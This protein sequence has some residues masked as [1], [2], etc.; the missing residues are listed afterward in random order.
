M[1]QVK[2]IAEQLSEPFDPQDIEWRVQQAGE[3]NGKKW[4]MVLAYIDNRAIMGRLD[5]V[6]G[7]AGWQN[8]YQPL[9]DGGIICGIKAKIGDEWIVKYDGADKTNIEATKGGLSNAMKRAGAQWGIGRYL[10]GLEATF[11]KPQDGKAPDHDNY[12]SGYS[13]DF[14]K[15]YFE[16]PQLPSWALPKG[17][18]V[19]VT[20][21]ETN[22]E[23]SYDER[24]KQLKEITAVGIQLGYD[25][26][27]LDKRI[28]KLNNSNDAKSLLTNFREMMKAE[29]SKKEE[30]PFK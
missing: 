17:A 9:P 26:A 10:Y 15:Y 1:A 20:K 18:K 19:E 16:R 27:T 21:T 12:I 3:A 2:E 4:A 22:P 29:K 13:K 25:I 28:A 23:W 7:I 5:K 24:D 8:E 11:V 6:F 30:V 14:G